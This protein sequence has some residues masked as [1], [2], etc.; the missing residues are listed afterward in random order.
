MLHVCAE[1]KLWD[2]VPR[3]VE[4]GERRGGLFNTGTHSA[5]L[6]VFQKRG[7]VRDSIGLLESHFAK[8]VGRDSAFAIPMVF[9]TA[10][11]SRFYNVCRVL[12]RYAAVSGNIAFNMQNVVATSLIKNNDE[13]N[14]SASHLW[15]ITAGKVIVGTD[16]DVSGLASQYRFLNEDGL[17]NPMKVLAQWT[18]DDGP[19]QEQ[20]SLAYT[21]LQ[22]DLTAY[23]HF[24]RLRS[25]QLFDLLKKAYELDCEWMHRKKVRQYSD[26]SW[27]IEDAIEVP[28][29]PLQDPSV[30]PQ[31]LLWPTGKDVGDGGRYV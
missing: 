27:M 23:K 14:N 5:L 20:L 15:R 12:W 7:S 16:L 11:N 26:L 8:T 30:S 2:V 19:R 21:I 1:K 4:L 22:R 17:K 13:T 24:W 10:W 9:M 28:L 3:V 18:P 25:Q 29:K 6:K 31:H